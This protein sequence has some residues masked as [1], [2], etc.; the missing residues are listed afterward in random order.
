MFAHFVLILILF[1]LFA[2]IWIFLLLHVFR[3]HV[4][5]S[6]AYLCACGL[7][8]GWNFQVWSG[9]P[10][11]VHRYLFWNVFS[12]I[13][14]TNTHTHTHSFEF[15]MDFVLSKCALHVVVKFEVFFVFYFCNSSNELFQTSGSLIPTYSPNFYVLFCF[16]FWR[17]RQTP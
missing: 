8:V 17:N 1:I 16:K 4:Y 13:T 7:F 15:Q 10:I 9:M 14:T 5:V 3:V 11:F 2:F 12:Y 6:F